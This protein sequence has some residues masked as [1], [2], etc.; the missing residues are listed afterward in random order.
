[1]KIRKALQ[2]CKMTRLQDCEKLG[3]RSKAQF[4]AD[5]RNGKPFFTL[6]SEP[7]TLSHSQKTMTRSIYTTKRTFIGRLPHGADLLESITKIVN[8]ENIRV[9]KVTAI[10]AVQNGAVSYYDQTT[11]QYERIEFDKP[12]E[13]LSCIGNVSVFK[14]RSMVHCHIVFSDREGKCFG[15]HLANGCTVFACEIIIE[16][17]EG[18]RL[19][20][21][22]DE[23]TGLPLWQERT[24]LI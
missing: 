24:V 18:D 16:E 10:G 2:D 3:T 20:R 17:L 22:F 6:C 19:L 4:D 8:E 7:L 15:G 13:I 23:T 14:Q 21:D 12:M 11:K 9:G 1:L 5:N